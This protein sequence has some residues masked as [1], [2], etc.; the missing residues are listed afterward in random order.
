ME[1]SEF[2]VE[3]LNQSISLNSHWRNARI[4]LKNSIQI[5]ASQVNK[6]ESLALILFTEG[7]KTGK[8]QQLVSSVGPESFNSFTCITTDKA[9]EVIE[10]ACSS[11][12]EKS[13]YSLVD[14]AR[15]DSAPHQNKQQWILHFRQKRTR[16]SLK[17][18]PL[19]I[20]SSPS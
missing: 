18:P 12:K 10:A 13:M 17:T 16:Y 19:E 1:T 20:P 9:E 11:S 14:C 8:L 6:A 15:L 4:S 7:L 5:T 2:V 3:N